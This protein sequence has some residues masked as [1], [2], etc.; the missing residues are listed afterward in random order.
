MLLP[1]TWEIGWQSASRANRNSQTER[2]LVNKRRLGPASSAKR[3]S[4][5][6]GIPPCAT[7]RRLAA[8]SIWRCCDTSVPHREDQRRLGDVV[9]VANGKD[10]GADRAELQHARAPGVG[11]LVDQHAHDARGLE[12]L[13]LDLHA[14]H[15]ELAS[16]G[17]GLRG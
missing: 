11:V 14:F 17:E 4:A 15:G 12:G 8:R 7:R 6:N 13:G 9:I 10:R 16:G 2:S 5:R 1:I 3:S